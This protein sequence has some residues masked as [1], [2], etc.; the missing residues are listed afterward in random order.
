MAK[1]ISLDELHAQ[2]G[3]SAN[4][5]NDIIKH[6]ATAP[7]NFVEL[8]K[9]SIA[10]PLND[11]VNFSLE[12]KKLSQ[13]Y[14]DYI[15]EQGK[16]SGYIE[17][18]IT[19][20][21]PCFIGGNGEEF[22]APTGEPLIPGSSLRGMVKNIFKMVTCGTMLGN[23]DVNDKHLYSRGLAQKGSFAKYYS[24][25]M[26]ENKTI[27]DKDG[28][29][30]NILVSKAQGGFLIKIKDK[31]YICP[32][33]GKAKKFQRQQA[34]KARI[35]YDEHESSAYCYTGD[36]KGKMHYYYIANASW[37]SEN[38]LDVPDEVV[39]DYRADKNRKGLDLFKEALKGNSAA[40]FAHNKLVEMVA[41]CY[42]VAAD[43]NKVL[44]FGH[45]RYYRIPYEKS[46]SEHIPTA[47]NDETIIDFAAA[48]FG[49]KEHWAS[50]VFFTDA[51]LDGKAKK[52][53]KEYTHPLM[54]PN[55]TSFQLYLQQNGNKLLHW[56]DD[57]TIRGYKMYWHQKNY[58][59]SWKIDL[60]KDKKVDGMMP[61]RPLAKGNSFKGR[62]RFQDLSDIELGALLEVFA[63]SKNGNETYY[64][65]GMGKSIGMGSVKITSKLYL[66]DETKRYS[67]LFSEGNWQEAIS[68]G[69][70][71]VYLQSFRT[72]LANKMQDKAV[73]EQYDKLMQALKCMLSWDNTKKAG[74][75]DKLKYMQIGV[76]TDSRY[77]DRSILPTPQEVVKQ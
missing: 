17:L 75:N 56:D 55:P 5:K 7:Y 70:E 58:D 6:D 65:L 39:R 77:K 63:L 22:F 47:V 33:E 35:D 44:H 54:S 43:N 2:R 68:D 11:K 27:K 48:V 67:S 49:S 23:E 64:K 52:L 36:M 31:Y 8:P 69:D 60:N 10:A 4:G 12:Q 72:Y 42:Y 38:W 50:R 30:K 41:P 73:K 32:A 25:R 37:D 34:K 20:E 66:C 76:K 29:R 13:A 59:N 19:T 61:I 18:A 51:V 53:D 28:N 71:S 14:K 3:Y 57:T 62:I 26:T 9:L 24:S 45:G 74:W 15:L 21:T 46:I 16:N 40:G 1:E